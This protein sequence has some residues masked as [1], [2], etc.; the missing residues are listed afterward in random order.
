M[1][2]RLEV[3]SDFRGDEWPREN[4]PSL[5]CL[6]IFFLEACLHRD[7]MTGLVSVVASLTVLVRVPDSEGSYKIVRTTVALS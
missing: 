6:V 4:V 7:D 3:Q 5:D 1:W 2:A